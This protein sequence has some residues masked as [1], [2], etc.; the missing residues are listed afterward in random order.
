M[1][2]EWQS[3]SSTS[4]TSLSVF[5]CSS[6]PGSFL[7]CFSHL[8]KGPHAL[9]LRTF[10]H[11]TPYLNS[12]FCSLP[13]TCCLLAP[14]HFS[15]LCQHL[16]HREIIPSARLGFYVTITLKECCF[17]QSQYLLLWVT[18]SYPFHHACFCSHY[19]LRA[20]LNNQSSC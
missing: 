7:F 4:T 6:H 8:R 1:F 17:S 19:I 15:D 5:Y 16:F 9:Y 10:A 14:N 20:Q 2:C 18:N 12:P 13:Y 3:T 11:A